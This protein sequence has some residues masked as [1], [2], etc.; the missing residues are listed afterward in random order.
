MPRSSPVIAIYDSRLFY[1]AH[2]SDTETIDEGSIEGEIEIS[3]PMADQWSETT[4][5]TVLR[6]RVNRTHT[7]FHN[8]F[9]VVKSIW[10]GQVELEREHLGNGL[11]PERKTEHI[12]HA[13]TPDSISSETI[14]STDTFVPRQPPRTYID[15]VVQGSVDDDGQKSIN[16]V[17]QGVPVR[18][19]STTSHTDSRLA[20]QNRLNRTTQHLKSQV[21]PASPID[22]GRIISSRTNE[23]P[24][25]SACQ[26]VVYPLESLHVMDRIFHKYCFRCRKCQRT[27]S[28]RTFNV[29]N[30]HPYCEPHYIELFRVRG[31]FGATALDKAV[32]EDDDYLLHQTAVQ[33][34]TPAETAKDRPP[35]LVTQTLVAK[36]QQMSDLSKSSHDI[37]QGEPLAIPRPMSLTPENTTRE[38]RARSLSLGKHTIP[39]PFLQASNLKVHKEVPVPEET[40]KNPNTQNDE[41]YPHPGITKDLIAKFSRFSSN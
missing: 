6:Q 34:S 29:G 36:F 23:K 26:K 41:E 20:E 38:V 17:N 37:R 11:M 15:R 24:R 5:A 28:V 35:P 31:R 13:I 8:S 39:T 3:R 30:G 40:V 9:P 4:Y 32:E 27:L 21:C 22:S 7:S 1:D 14:Y 18:Q 12:R 2:A 19:E 10:L 33:S 25:C 16:T